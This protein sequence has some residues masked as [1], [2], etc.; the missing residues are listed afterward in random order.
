MEQGG[1]LLSKQTQ[2]VSKA[3][4]KKCLEVFLIDGEPVFLLLMMLPGYTFGN[5]KIYSHRVAKTL[6]VSGSKKNT[7]TDGIPFYARPLL[8]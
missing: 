1:V 8:W 6:G 7:G 2:Q 3:G 5:F 4:E